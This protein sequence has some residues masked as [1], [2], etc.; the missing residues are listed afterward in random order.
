MG[1]CLEM[2]SIMAGSSELQKCLDRYTD[3]NNSCLYVQKRVKADNTGKFFQAVP[4]TIF[5]KKTKNRKKAL[6]LD[7]TVEILE[8]ILEKVG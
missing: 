1:D 2:E 5:G 6:T 4:L 3:L 7:E 8:A